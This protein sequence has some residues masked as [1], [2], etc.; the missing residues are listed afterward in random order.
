M[1]LELEITRRNYTIYLATAYST[2]IEIR[3]QGCL[4]KNVYVTPAFSTCLCLCE[5]FSPLSMRERYTVQIYGAHPA[6]LRKIERQTRYVVQIRHYLG[7]DE[8]FPWLRAIEPSV[9]IPCPTELGQY[10]TLN[11]DCDSRHKRMGIDENT[12]EEPCL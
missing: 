6:T 12:F 7:G 8:V 11:G 1:E 9:T 3:I 2:Y 5:L 10:I 4:P